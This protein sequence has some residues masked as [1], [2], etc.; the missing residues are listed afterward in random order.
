M[1]QS[2]GKIGGMT[3][4]APV[5]EQMRKVSA[6]PGFANAERL[7]RFLE[8]TIEAHLNGE[9]DQIKEYLIG[10]EVFDRP[11]DYDPRL[12]PIVRVEARRL[13]QRLAEYYA[14][15]GAEDE[16][17]IGYP[18][19]SYAPEI[20]RGVEESAVAGTNPPSRRRLWWL[21]IPPLLPAIYLATRKTP[22]PPNATAIVPAR[23]TFGDPK[24][25][26]EGDEAIAEAITNQAANRGKAP[27]IGWPVVRE[28]RGKG[29]ELAGLGSRLGATYVLAVSVRRAGE[30]RRVTV[31]L[32]EPATGR[33]RWVEDFYAQDLGT[34][35]DVERLAAAIV[36]DLETALGYHQ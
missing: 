19:G 17:R 8:F 7:R 29:V 28:L 11:E 14:G 35:A 4:Q 13:R 16:I 15:P 6:S 9:A 25:L 3:D 24:G 23:W 27:I 12:D 1:S 33:K 10:R 22:P 21:A 34:P 18:K 31:Y 36:V 32:M 26:E 30:S 5:R 20:T 2:G